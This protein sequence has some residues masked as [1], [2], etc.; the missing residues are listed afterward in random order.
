MIFFIVMLNLLSDLAKYSTGGSAKRLGE[1]AL[2]PRLQKMITF[3][4]DLGG[5]F[6]VQDSVNNNFRLCCLALLGARVGVMGIGRELIFNQVL[7]KL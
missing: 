5:R 1:I 7:G 3:L 2:P 4:P 6:R